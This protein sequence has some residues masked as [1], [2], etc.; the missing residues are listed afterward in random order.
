M[1]KPFY[2]NI[3]H[4][5]FDI[6]QWHLKRWGKFGNGSVQKL[7]YVCADILVCPYSMSL[8]KTSTVKKRKTDFIIK[9]MVRLK[10]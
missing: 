10:G 2:L 1:L 3:L 6:Q 5:G 8:R 9:E 4:K 7:L